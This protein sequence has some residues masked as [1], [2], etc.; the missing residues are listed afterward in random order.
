MIELFNCDS[1]E[2]MRSL[3]DKSIDLIVTDPPYEVEIGGGGTVNTVKRFNK[4]LSHLTEDK[5]DCGL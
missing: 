3:S 2:Y 5:I 4:S 1:L